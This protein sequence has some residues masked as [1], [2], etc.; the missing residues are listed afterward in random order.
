MSW[1]SGYQNRS[2]FVD[3]GAKLQGVAGRKERPSSTKPIS[4][5]SAVSSREEAS[6]R[7]TTAPS[8]RNPVATDIIGFNSE[9]FQDNLSSSNVGSFNVLNLNG[10]RLNL[11]SFEQEGIV[12]SF[13]QD[14]FPL[15][16]LTVQHSFIGSWLWHVPQFPT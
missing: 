1:I 10:P 15:G 9:I 14:L 12:A 5:S 13:V 6:A 2:K 8:E 11:R 7:Q 3:E 16:R 4:E